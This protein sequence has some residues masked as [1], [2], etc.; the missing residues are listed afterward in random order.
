VWHLGANRY[1]ELAERYKVLTHRR[2]KLA[3]D[4]NI[5]ERYQNVYPTKQQ[6]GT[7]LF[8]LVHEA[9]TSFDRLALYFENSLL[10]PDLD[11]LPSAAAAVS[12]VE[13]IGEKLVVESAGGV[14]VPWKDGAT[15][16]GQVWPVLDGETLWLP[17]GAHAVEASERQ[18]A[19]RILRFNGA[20]RGVS[21]GGDDRVQVSYSSSSRALAVLSAVPSRIEVDGVE[22][23]PLVAGT[24]TQTVLLPRGQH[25][26]TFFAPVRFLAKRQ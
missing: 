10:T 24:E 9:A 19:L 4:L 22:Q 26:V 15:V 20:I 23:D 21:V 14:G 17:A 11:L 6:T 8:Q 5:V 16:D 2:E 3:I 18:L 1:R 25:V 7:E 12:R 13:R